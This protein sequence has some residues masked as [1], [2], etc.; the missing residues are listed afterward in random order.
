MLTRWLAA[1]CAVAGVGVLAGLGWALL[2]AAVVLAVLPEPSFMLDLV[3]RGRRLAAGA[4]EKARRRLAVRGAGRRAV[5][6]ASM[7]AAL[8]LGPVGFAVVAGVGVGLIAAA[9][10]LAALSLLAGWNA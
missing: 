4:G 5:A 8:V 10:A 7:P 6:V 2:A 1:S 9:V 3:G